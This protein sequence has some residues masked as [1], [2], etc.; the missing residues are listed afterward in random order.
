LSFQIRFDPSL[1]VVRAKFFGPVT[2]EDK[3]ASARQ[4][5]EKYGHLH[6]LML[7]VDVRDADILLSMEERKQFGQYAA[8]LQGLSH[9][10]T[11]VLH[12]PHV[13]ANVVIDHWAQSEGMQLAE[14]VTEP[15]ALSWLAEESSV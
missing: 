7:I 15:A 6:P 9:A 10:R 4:V 1:R 3:L 13:N 8:H 12:A 5:A 11:A 14:F 2:L